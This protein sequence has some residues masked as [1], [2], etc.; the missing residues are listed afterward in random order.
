[1]LELDAEDE[2]GHALDPIG[3]DQPDDD[4]DDDDDDM[5]DF[6]DPERLARM[7]RSSESA[8]GGVPFH[9]PASPLCHSGPRI[10]CRLVTYL[11][12]TQTGKATEPM[13]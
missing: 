6:D 1:M 4:E 8:P 3:E 5:S 12:A 13:L 11:Q 9:G 2:E 7:K 10:A